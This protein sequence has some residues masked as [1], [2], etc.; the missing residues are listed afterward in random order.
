MELAE[1]RSRRLFAQRLRGAGGAARPGAAGPGATGRRAGKDRP[2]AADASPADLVRDALAVQSQEYLPAQWGLAQ[3]L[4]TA[5][6]PD[7]AAVAALIDDGA[8][9]RT[10]VLRPTW[11]FVHP[12]DARWL[13]GLS[14]ERVHRQNGTMYRRGGIEGPL[15]ATGLDVIA[16]EVA[17][18]HRTRVELQTA[19]ARA[20]IDLSGPDLAHLIMYAE[21]ERVIISGPSVG[22]QRTYAAFDE[23]VPP[24]R[25][26]DRAEALAELAERYL[27]TRSPASAR[28]LATW[29]GFT[30]ADARQALADAADRTGDR[31]TRF[32]GTDGAAPGSAGSAGSGGSADELWHDASV[33]AAW[34]ARAT[35]AGAPEPA[36]DPS[37]VDLLQAYD[38]YVMGYAAP[39]AFLQPPG[40][41]ATIF[42][43]FPLHA[44]MIGGVMCGRWAPTVQG[45]RARVRIVPWRRLSRAELRSR[46]AAIAEVE[47]FLGVPVA[48]EVERVTRV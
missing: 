19:L 8:I 38:E 24:S 37:R 14:A 30:L 23:R 29:S 43:E 18:G 47:A 2:D 33:S 34:A 45:R 27:L 40:A 7:R 36:D 6:R 35:G 44:L 9:L 39:R 5:N 46:D 26:R 15:L 11:H 1:L 25:E 22:A 17:G 13:V 31:I 28:D 41:A 21:L 48:V 12:A 4:P 10:H 42:S 16:G 20:G 32:G 3:R